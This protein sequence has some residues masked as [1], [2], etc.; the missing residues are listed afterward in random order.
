[1]TD[2]SKDDTGMRRWARTLCIQCV[3]PAGSGSSRPLSHSGSRSRLASPARSGCALP[4]RV[5]SPERRLPH[6]ILVTALQ[7]WLPANTKRQRPAESIS[8]ARVSV[9][10]PRARPG[11]PFPAPPS[12]RSS[13]SRTRHQD[14]RRLSRSALPRRLI[15]RARIPQ[16]RRS[17][18]LGAPLGSTRFVASRL[19]NRRRSSRSKP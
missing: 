1:M 9:A 16:D 4:T 8:T 7:D 17:P 11:S 13:W 12:R 14:S 6:R 18:E 15:I 3:T 19:V 5:P 2:C 10:A